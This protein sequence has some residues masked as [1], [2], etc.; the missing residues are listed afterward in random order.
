MVLGKV[1]CT[2]TRD[3]CCY[4]YSISLIPD[5]VLNTYCRFCDYCATGEDITKSV[6]EV[7]SN[8]GGALKPV[9]KAG[10]WI[11]S[12]CANWIPEIFVK[13]INDEKLIVSLDKL[14]KKRF[15]LKC[16]LC[17][18]KGACIQCNYGRCQTPAHPW[19]V[20]KYPEKGFTK[21]VI[22]NEDG[23]PQW[24][25]FCKVHAHGVSEP[26]KPKAKPKIVQQLAPLPIFEPTEEKVIIRGGS[27]RMSNTRDGNRQ[28]SMG[29]SMKKVIV[30]SMM[31]KVAVDNSITVTTNKVEKEEIKK[32]PIRITNTATKSSI[33][34]ENSKSRV[35]KIDDS[36][37][38]NENVLSSSI[39]PSKL[40]G[41]S[42]SFPVFTLNE[43]PGQSEGEAMDLDHFWNVMSMQFPED[44]SLEVGWNDIFY[45][46]F[47]VCF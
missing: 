42:R 33:L 40:S 3:Y 27:R 31:P 9:D 2:Y 23:E 13:D 25:I 7:C 34:S 41:N 44:H 43:W 35:I 8:S 45:F 6:C 19:C 28:L 20:I 39:S 29:H 30:K 16:A 14:D 11:H 38:E 37:S 22:K 12:L 15:R 4:H 17:N 46:L 21:R 10:K 24:E 1:Y 47:C 18:T 5:S 36:D 26:L 32:N